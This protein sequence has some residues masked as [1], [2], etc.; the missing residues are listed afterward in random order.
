MYSMVSGH[1]C[2]IHLHG[3]RQHLV[4]TLWGHPVSHVRHPQ[5]DVCQPTLHDYGLGKCSQ[6]TSSH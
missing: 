6:T 2:F 5:P 4:P 3:R 1:L